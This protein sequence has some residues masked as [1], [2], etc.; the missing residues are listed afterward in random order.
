ML[1]NFLG[2]VAAS[3]E[4]WTMDYTSIVSALQSGMQIIG[5][6]AGDMIEGVA[7][8]AVAVAGGYIIIRIG[9]KVFRRIAG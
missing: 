1:M 6:A 5:T 4:A 7:P 9:M 2:A 8:V 3:G